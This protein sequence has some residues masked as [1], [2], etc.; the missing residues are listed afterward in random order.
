[1]RR[2]KLKM[3]AINNYVGI[4]NRDDP[5]RFYKLPFVGN[6][7]R[8]RIARCLDELSGGER[9]LEIG[10]GSGVTFLNLNEMYKE[11][12]GLD[13][14]ANAELITAMFKTLGIRTFLKNGNVLDL[15]YQDSYFDSVLLI[16]ML[17]HL[18]PELLIPAFR[19]IYRVL[20]KNGQIVYGVPVDKKIMNRAFRMLG[21]NI[22]K[23]HFSNQKQVAA[24]SKAIFK[25]VAISN[26]CV[27]P[28]GRLYEIGCSI[29]HES[30]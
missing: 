27:W 4:I 25:E 26:I 5:I 13:L 2:Q 30:V 16:S 15:P 6:I 11:I 3:L 20:K 17:E 28:F 10:F 12:H 19:E 21:Y 9:I 14:T 1:M 23:H 8:Q 29:K 18:K 7:Y 22:K 24:A